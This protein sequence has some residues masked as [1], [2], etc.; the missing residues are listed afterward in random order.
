MGDLPGGMFSHDI[1]CLIPD[2]RPTLNR[3]KP[4]SLRPT[5][6]CEQDLSA[7][8]RLQ[9]LLER[10]LE[11]VEWVDLL[12]GGPERSLSDE[13][14]QLLVHLPDLCARRS[15]YPIDQPEAVEAETTVDELAGRHGRKLPTEEGVDDNRA[16]RFERLGQ[17]AH[18]RAAHHIEDE[19]QLLPVERLCN[20]LVESVAL[21]DNA[22]TSPLPHLVDRVVPADDMQRLD[23]GEL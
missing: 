10:F 3:S 4:I 23:A 8:M 14:A 13:V 2:G 16:A 15:A 12:H 6:K 18:G 22:V 9:R 1:Q 7:A 19:T 11:L 21:E 20:L 17:L 5:P